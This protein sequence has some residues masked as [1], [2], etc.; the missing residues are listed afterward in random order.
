MRYAETLSRGNGPRGKTQSV[1]TKSAEKERQAQTPGGV[2]AT[3]RGVGSAPFGS[4]SQEES[5]SHTITSYASTITSNFQK[6]EGNFIGKLCSTIW[7]ARRMSKSQI[8]LSYRAVDA[9][10]CA[11]FSIGATWRGFRRCT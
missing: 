10:T 7:Y 4:L 2:Q 11:G 1:T 3:R 6:A 8:S 5:G 9:T